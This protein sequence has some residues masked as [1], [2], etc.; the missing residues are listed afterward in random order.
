MIKAVFFDLD[1]TLI[2]FKLDVQ[3]AKE[4]VVKV[5]QSTIPKAHGIDYRQSYMTMLD[6]V[7]RISDDET[8]LKVRSAIFRVLD[9]F[10][11]KAAKESILRKGAL[12]ALSALKEQGKIVALLTNS[13]KKAVD[14]ILEKFNIRK[15]FDIVLTRDEVKFMK[16]SPEGI[17]HLLSL[18]KVKADE[19]LTVGDGVIDIIPSK[20][21]GIKTVVVVGG[22]TPIEKLVQEKPDY[23]IHSLGELL[24]LIT[25]S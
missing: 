4:E 6:E 8:Y 18:F 14:E 19:C 23:I 17:Y 3:S 22:Y 2:E 20:A 11:E 16:P 12:E 7:R 13:G 25:S 15:Y 5:I 24:P 9:K 10:E 21:A 1:G